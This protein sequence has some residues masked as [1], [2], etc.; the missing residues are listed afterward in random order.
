MDRIYNVV[1]VIHDIGH[2]STVQNACGIVN[3]LEELQHMG[4][5]ASSIIRKTTG[6]VVNLTKQLINTDHSEIKMVYSYEDGTPAVQYVATVVLYDKAFPE[7]ILQSV[8]DIVD[9]IWKTIAHE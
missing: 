4:D 8:V 3:S 9:D 7:E 1:A 2:G 6:H 5:A